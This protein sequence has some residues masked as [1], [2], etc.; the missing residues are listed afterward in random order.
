MDRP[1]AKI[2]RRKPFESPENTLDVARCRAPGYPSRFGRSIHEYPRAGIR[3][4]TR[5]AAS[6]DLAYRIHIFNQPSRY[7]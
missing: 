4:A 7:F 6:A 1:V 3:W 2:D 5:L